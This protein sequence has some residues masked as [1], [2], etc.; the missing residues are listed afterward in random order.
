M[1]HL[2]NEAPAVAAGGEIVTDQSVILNDGLSG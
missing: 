1:G 2:L